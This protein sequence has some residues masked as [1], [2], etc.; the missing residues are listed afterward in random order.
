M[1]RFFLFLVILMIGSLA[2]AEEFPAVHVYEK[3]A[4]S[5]V[6][7]ISKFEGKPSL[8]GAGSIIAKRGTILTSAH[9]VV[10]REGGK[11]A[12]IVQ[13]FIK[14]DRVTG[15]FHRDPARRYNAEI[16]VYDSNLDLAVLKI[17]NLHEEI[18]PI[19]F[20]RTEEVRIGEEVVAIG[21]PEQ[22]GFWTVTYGHI[23]GEIENQSSV[24]GKD[25]YQTDT[26]VN[27][28]NSGGPLLDRRGYLVG[29]TANIARVG[30]GN[31][32]ITGVN[33]AVKSGIAGQW[34]EKSGYPSP[35]GN[36]PGE[37]DSGSVAVKKDAAPVLPKQ[38]V[39]PPA[40]PAREQVKGPMG[41]DKASQPTAK[42]EAEN[43]RAQPTREQ[44]R[45]PKEDR[46]LTPKRP[47]RM[48]EFL[49]EVERD[50]SDMME[51]MRGKIRR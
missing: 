4:K 15:D 21:H 27:R 12:A 16:A 40:E 36:S 31:L 17:R 11:P 23:S 47:Y 46:I 18:E 48:D 42:D 32:P 38:D 1:K 6:L 45:A 9:V 22:G 44:E 37:T 19:P 2:W 14:P 29:V 33:F 35:Y 25:V 7:I 24:S 26:N 13:V 3:T 43:V 5:V 50:M 39:P 20:A 28:G 30:A 8:I 41:Q 51:E 10:D 49:A 34:L